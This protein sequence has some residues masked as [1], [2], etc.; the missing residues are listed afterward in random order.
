MLFVCAPL[1]VWA[2]NQVPVA[3]WS[4]YGQLQPGVTVSFYSAFWDPD[5]GYITAYRWY[6]NGVLVSSSSS[7]AFTETLAEGQTSKTITLKLE[8]R[9]DE[10][11]WNSKTEQITI[12]TAG[13]TE[14]YLTDHLGSIRTTID[15]TTGAVLGYDDYYPFGLAMPGRSSNT[16]KSV[17]I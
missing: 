1:Q 8:V 11:T 3:L 14:Y 13:R 16:G 9:D 17:T 12:T 10:N 4:V 2:N 5:G 15:G 6:K 7:Y